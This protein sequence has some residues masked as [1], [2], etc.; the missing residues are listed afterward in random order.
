MLGL[1]LVQHDGNASG[2]EEH[3]MATAQDYDFALLPPAWKPMEIEGRSFWLEMPFYENYQAL[4]ERAGVAD[5]PFV[6]HGALRVHWDVMERPESELYQ[7]L[8]ALP[9]PVILRSGYHHFEEGTRHVDE[10]VYQR[11]VADFGDRFLGVHGIHERMGALEWG[12]PM[13]QVLE[14]IRTKTGIEV[15]PPATAAEA[16]EVMRAQYANVSQR[17]FFKVYGTTASPVDHFLMELGIGLSACEVGPWIPCASM[18]F[19]ASRGA[20]RQY[21][22][23]WGTVTAGWGKGI[24][25]DSHCAFNHL[26]PGG[27]TTRDT[28]GYMD[29]GPHGG[30]SYSLQKRLLYTAFMAGANLHAHESDCLYMGGTPHTSRTLQS[31][32]VA[33]YDHRTIETVD[34]LVRVLRDK[35]HHLSPIGEMYRDFYNRVASVRDR[36]TPYTPVALLFHRHHGT[37]FAYSSDTILNAK[38]PYGPGDYMTRAMINTIW[39]W[40]SQPITSWGNTEARVLVAGP[41]G[42]LFDILTEDAS[43]ETLQSYRVLVLTGPVE[44]DAVLSAKLKDYVAN[45]G[46]LVAN[47]MQLNEHLDAAFFGAKLEEGAIE[48][49]HVYS[50]GREAAMQKPDSFTIRKARLTD[51][52]ALVWSE[53]EVP[54]CIRARRG[55]G[56]S[57]L[58]L[59]P[60]AMAP[61]GEN[62]LL[63]W[64]QELVGQ[65]LRRV[66][67]VQVDGS[68]QYLIN[69]T[70]RSWVVTLV[71]NAGVEKPPAKMA[72]IDHE[73]DADVMVRVLDEAR[74]APIDKAVEWL[75]GAPMDLS[76]DGSLVLGVP[77]GD[78][79]IVEFFTGE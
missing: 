29:E 15:A 6:T 70:P 49:G 63:R 57:L 71:N 14:E 76:K 60:W 37:A 39:P 11:F 40:E 69:R 4:F 23:P 61:N 59:V 51:G 18:Q 8:L 12:W 13:D 33:N 36:G 55:A 72:N 5:E 48:A 54:V 27:R 74:G 56:E 7:A 47:V 25:G 44:I 28:L 35:P 17:P 22:V 62:A 67:P 24:V 34:P 66:N 31:A 30:T 53:G 38:V 68:V 16:Y 43:L 65:L 19:A 46:V 9:N 52:E 78:L 3:D 75:T 32:F 21:G 1:G 45:G 2:M 50:H 20:S 10:S 77:A 73:K 79:R 64:F 26:W 58:C 42:D 41:H